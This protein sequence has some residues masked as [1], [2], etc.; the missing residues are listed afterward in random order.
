MLSGQAEITITKPDGRQ[1][2]QVIDNNISDGVFIELRN[3]I[4]SDGDGYNASYVPNHIKITL[5]NGGSYTAPASN[6]SLGNTITAT[7][8][9]ATYSLDSAPAGSAFTSYDS[10]VV[11]VELRSADNTVIAEAT[12]GNTTFTGGSDIDPSNV[13]D[14][15]DTV[16]CTYRLQFQDFSDSSQTFVASLIL[17]IQGGV[18]DISMSEYLLT[19]ADDDQLKSGSL[20][21]P[22]TA[23]A[24]SGTYTITGTPYFPSVGTSPTNLE[25][26]T[27]TGLRIMKKALSTGGD[28]TTRLASFV[29][30][31]NITAPFEFTLTKI[32]SAVT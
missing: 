16:S 2:T 8:V 9:W 7:K 28:N 25:I 10:Y 17:T 15:N 1:F 11:K 32:T 5:N 4:I 3:K 24:T 23:L 29:T 18:P 14:S 26:K 12:T 21:A 22:G 30:G 6:V 13:I 27:S 19:D 20:G 31:D